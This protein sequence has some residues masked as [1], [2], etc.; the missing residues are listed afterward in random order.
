MPS[1]YFNSFHGAPFSPNIFVIILI[2]ELSLFFSVSTNPIKIT[3][4]EIEAVQGDRLVIQCTGTGVVQYFWLFDGDPLDSPDIQIIGSHAAYL[5]IEKFKGTLV[6]EYSCHAI[7]SSGNELGHRS[8]II[9]V[10]ATK[11]SNVY[12]WIE[13]RYQARVKGKV[14][15]IT[16]NSTYHFHS[17]DW[18]FEGQPIN[19]NNR[20]IQQDGIHNPEITVTVGADTI[21]QYTCTVTG[22]KTTSESHSLLAFIAI[23]PPSVMARGAAATFTCSCS[24]AGRFFWLV[25]GSVLTSDVRKTGSKHETVTIPSLGDGNSGNYTCIAVHSSGLKL[26]SA[27]LII[28]SPGSSETQ[29]VTVEP[30]YRPVTVK[31]EYQVR[32]LNSRTKLTCTSANAVRFT[33]LL[34]RQPVPTS[35][36]IVTGTSGQKIRLTVTSKTVGNYSCEALATHD[37]RVTIGI[38]YGYIGVITLTPSQQTRSKGESAKFTCH[39][40]GAHTYLWFF[41]NVLILGE[42]NIGG[43]G[44]KNEVLTITSVREENEGNYSCECQDMH[45]AIGE[46]WG[47]LKVFNA[48]VSPIIVNVRPLRYTVRKGSST[49]FTCSSSKVTGVEFKWQLNNKSIARQNIEIKGSRNQRVIINAAGNSSAGRYRCIAVYSNGSKIPN[50]YANAYLSIAQGNNK[51]VIGVYP[52]VDYDK[53]GGRSLFS[54]AS[55]LALPR[56]WTFLRKSGELPK[57]VEKTGAGD[58]AIRIINIRKEN[59]GTYTCTI[60]NSNNVRYSAS[61]KLVVSGFMDGFDVTSKQFIISLNIVSITFLFQQQL[62]IV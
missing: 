13:P 26:G 55:N 11:P 36:A 32:M 48:K 49:A 58:Y 2:V 38:A 30:E 54:C 10:Q 22:L 47:I 19:R 28:R 57:N 7:G 25:D 3:F 42:S 52:K 37:Y 53:V 45:G 20:N 60:T 23:N 24:L 27:N 17:F 33:W 14:T 56:K 61:A 34:N 41:N 50:A 59:A 18:L 29:P 6:G 62:H 39:A 31:P 46:A 4:P 1:L 21:G 43:S 15:T 5:V 9:T 12:S 8:S 35:S 51:V 40:Q 16:C 44:R